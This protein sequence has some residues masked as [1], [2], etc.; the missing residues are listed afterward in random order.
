MCTPGI[1]DSDCSQAMTKE[2]AAK[3]PEV[4][5]ISIVIGPYLHDRWNVW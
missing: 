4:P 2:D 1:P 5:E 3:V